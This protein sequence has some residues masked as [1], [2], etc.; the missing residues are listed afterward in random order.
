M[1]QKRRYEWSTKNERRAWLAK[2][3]EDLAR[4]EVREEFEAWKAA[5]DEAG[6][7]TSAQ[8]TQHPIITMGSEKYTAVHATTQGSSCCY[9]S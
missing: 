8:P 7:Q 6:K 3:K 4:P 9:P 1:A 5:R 2:I